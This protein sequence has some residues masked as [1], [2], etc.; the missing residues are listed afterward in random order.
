LQSITQGVYQIT[1]MSTQI[2]TAAHEQS[3]VADEITKSIV[4]IAD[5]ANAS[6]EYANNLASS[7]SRLSA[8]SKEMKLILSRYSLDEQLFQQ[9]SSEMNMLSWE[10]SKEIGISESDR[11]HRQM[12]DM[13]NNVHLAVS[14]NRSQKAIANAINSLIDYTKVHF[15]WEEDMLA[16]ANYPRLAEHKEEHKKLLLEIKQHSQDFERG[17]VKVIEEAVSELNHWL[18]NHVV[19]SDKD[20]ANF[21]SKR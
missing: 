17:N 2:A 9:R 15:E 13:M 19:H 11:Q 8:M 18:V 14:Q 3:Y 12:V 5:E 1:D 21:M 6:S 7:G 16:Q 20:Y 10:K 4:S